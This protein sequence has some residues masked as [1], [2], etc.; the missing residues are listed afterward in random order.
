MEMSRED[1]CNYVKDLQQVEE[2][3]QKAHTAV[4]HFRW[5]ILL[6]NTYQ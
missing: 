2:V 4:D 1:A 5:V 3:V 6:S